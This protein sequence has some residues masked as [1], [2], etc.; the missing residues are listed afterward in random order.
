[1]LKNLLLFLS[2]HVGYARRGSAVQGS[3][4][5]DQSTSRKTAG[6]FCCV[7]SNDVYRQKLRLLRRLWQATR[8]GLWMVEDGF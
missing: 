6:R 7:T 2:P 8:V 5:G 3:S 4:A 1:M